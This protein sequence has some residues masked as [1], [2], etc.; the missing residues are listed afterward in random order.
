M[1]ESGNLDADNRVAVGQYL[2][3]VIPLSSSMKKES[4]DWS[5]NSRRS[6]RI[7]HGSSMISANMISVR[8]VVA[9]RSS[10]KFSEE[11]NGLREN[12]SNA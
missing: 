11:S 2:S 10:H 3:A 8:S 6:A 7:P 4:P 1:R 9:S 12:T 5:G